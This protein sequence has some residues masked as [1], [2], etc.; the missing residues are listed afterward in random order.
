MKILV[1]GAGI[2]GSYL[3]HILC[4]H[5]EVTILARGERRCELE[6]NGLVIR[7]H[8]QRKTTRD[9]PRIIGELDDRRYDLAFAVMPYDNMKIPAKQIGKIN[10]PIVVCVGND[11]YP[12][13]ISREIKVNSSDRKIVLFGFQATGGKRENGILICERAG[14][15]GMDIGALGCAPSK[16][17]KA[18][19]ENAFKSTG[20]KLRW[21]DDMRAYL[22]CHLA[23]ILPIAYLSY[24]CGGDLRKSTAKQRSMMLKASREGYKMLSSLGCPIQPKGDDKYFGNGIRGLLMRF[25][26]FVMAKTVLGDLAA[27]E[28]CRNSVSEMELLD[29]AFQRLSDK[30]G[31]PMPVWDKL[32]RQMPTWDELRAKYDFMKGKEKN[33]G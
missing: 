28:H 26:Y 3:A 19:I 11:P 12:E 22:H 10:A 13:K 21:Q 18:R 2:I 20:Y 33:E 16:K 14:K 25:L 9:H 31:M 27:C 5:N 29:S 1:F 24:I 7:H 8:L 17:L 30:S 32:R 4:M 15:G 23:A 6:K